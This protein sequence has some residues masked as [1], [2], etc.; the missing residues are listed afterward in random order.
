MEDVKNY[1]KIDKP[2]LIYYYYVFFDTKEYL[3]DQLFINHKV[4][5]S[6]DKEYVKQGIPYVAIFCKIKKKDEGNFL[7]ALAELPNKMLIMGNRGYISYCRNL[8][9]TADTM[10]NKK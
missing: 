2:S 9:N 5:V 10:F 1:W 7:K 4:T 8:M 6:F 3:A